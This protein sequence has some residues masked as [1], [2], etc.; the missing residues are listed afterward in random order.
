LTLTDEDF[1]Y[2]LAAQ[3]DSGYAPEARFVANA[4]SIDP[5]RAP[6]PGDTVLVFVHGAGSPES[7]EL[8]DSRDGLKKLTPDEQPVYV[9]RIKELKSIFSAKQPQ[10]SAI[11]AWLVRCAE[12][13]ATRWDAAFDLE[14]G[15]RQV[16]RHAGR[17]ETPQAADKSTPINDE[18][19]DMITIAKALTDE[20]KTSL[21]N[22][23]LSLGSVDFPDG[24]LSAAD[25]Q[26]IKL[27]RRWAPRET[28]V[29]LLDRL[30]G[31]PSASGDDTYVMY[32]IAAVTNDSEAAQ[33]AKRYSQLSTSTIQNVDGDHDPRRNVLEQFVARVERS[34]NSLESTK[35]PR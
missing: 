28:A 12:D 1:R 19:R 20:Q 22:I 33:Y 25:R 27:V 23:L 15:F 18:F 30:K 16:D 6:E 7:L 21:T 24:N 5:S 3:P 8:V 34:L 31:G 4:A 13:P 10:P 2:R 32:M 9:D 11:A 35:D 14:R 17:K 26:L 29:H